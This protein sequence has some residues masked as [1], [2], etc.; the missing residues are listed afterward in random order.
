MDIVKRSPVTDDTERLVQQALDS[1]PSA[2]RVPCVVTPEVAL[3]LRAAFDTNRVGW[4]FTL[5]VPEPGEQS[6]PYVVLM[7]T[8]P[9]GIRYMQVFIPQDR[10][11]AIEKWADINMWKYGDPWPVDTATVQEV[12][13]DG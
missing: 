12:R 9:N 11:D 4:R 10:H 8:I 5:E 2:S 7:E 13:A 1:A 6:G 3:C